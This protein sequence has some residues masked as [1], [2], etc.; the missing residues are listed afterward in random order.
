MIQRCPNILQCLEQPHAPKLSS[1]KCSCI[2][3]EKPCLE[4]RFI[5]SNCPFNINDYCKVKFYL[6]IYLVRQEGEEGKEQER[7]RQALSRGLWSPSAGTTGQD[8]GHTCA[9][10]TAQPKNLTC[11]W[12][13]ALQ[14]IALPLRQCSWANVKWFFL[15][16]WIKKLI[17]DGNWEAHLWLLKV[18]VGL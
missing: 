3:L 1:V 17:F 4:I 6:V 10:C 12:P 11:Q 18:V 5:E 13:P 15:D 9:V 8:R 2:D 14:S 7:E 16:L